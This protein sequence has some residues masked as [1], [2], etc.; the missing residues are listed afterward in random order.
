MHSRNVN[1]LRW[2]F[3]IYF[4]LSTATYTV[5]LL[6]V[7]LGWVLFHCSFSFMIVLHLPVLGFTV[8]V[9]KERKITAVTKWTQSEG[10]VHTI[11]LMFLW[12]LQCN[13]IE[14][15]NQFRQIF[16][17]L[18]QKKMCLHFKQDVLKGGILAFPCSCAGCTSSHSGLVYLVIYFG[19][20]GVQEGIS[21]RTR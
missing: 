17:K 9:Q 14:K 20:G 2:V 4:D 15:H 19:G 13:L 7:V 18:F 16:A 5:L 11:V 12:V 21:E 1:P 8:S 3:F 6:F 10:K